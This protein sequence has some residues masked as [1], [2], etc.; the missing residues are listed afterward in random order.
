MAKVF[1]GGTRQLKWKNLA[2]LQRAFAM[3]QNSQP[4]LILNLDLAR[5]SQFLEKIRQSYAVILVSLGDISP[6]FVLDAL[7]LGKPVILTR[8]TGL[9]ERLGE[10]V[11]WVD[12]E[13]E[14]EITEK[15]LWLAQSENYQQALAR[16]SHFNFK[17]SWSE[18][19]REFMSL[20]QKL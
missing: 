8:E 10:S 6:N 1:I 13:N 9:R 5:H 2:R 11:L 17:H 18:I 7:R 15:I 16:V 4:D 14:T 12:P 19:A 3:A 20:A